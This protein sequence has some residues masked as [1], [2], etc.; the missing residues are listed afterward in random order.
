[1]T[2]VVG[3]DFP[4]AVGETKGA[5]VALQ[6]VVIFARSKALFENRCLLLLVDITVVVVI[7]FLRCNQLICRRRRGY[8]RNKIGTLG[9]TQRSLPLIK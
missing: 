2:R 1:M 6:R 7:F 5:Q 9:K 4:F 3:S 8:I